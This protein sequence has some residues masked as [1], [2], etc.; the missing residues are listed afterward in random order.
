MEAK[1]GKKRK[2]DTQKPDVP[3]LF[4]H[5]A[6]QPIKSNVHRVQQQ[7]NHITLPTIYVPKLYKE[8]GL[9]AIKTASDLRS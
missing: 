6:H 2:K 9:S 3:S 4:T 5:F 8:T 7:K 1:K